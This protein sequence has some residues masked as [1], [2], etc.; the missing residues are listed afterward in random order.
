MPVEITPAVASY[1]FCLWLLSLIHCDK[2]GNKG[3]QRVCSGDEFA[4]VSHRKQ[5]Q[6]LS[7]ADIGITNLKEKTQAVNHS[8]CCFHV[9]SLQPL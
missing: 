3:E 5:E 9:V 1:T 2:S 6:S 7:S 4:D 8:P